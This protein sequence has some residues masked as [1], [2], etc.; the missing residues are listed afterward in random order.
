MILG[1]FLK[2]FDDFFKACPK[3]RIKTQP[4]GRPGPNSDKN[5]PIRG[6]DKIPKNLTF[7]GQAS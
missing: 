1:G 5:C 3:I 2:I 7:F 4:C 6:P